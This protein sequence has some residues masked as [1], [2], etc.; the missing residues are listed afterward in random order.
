MD[1]GNGGFYIISNFDTEFSGAATSIGNS[2]STEYDTDSN[3]VFIVDAANSGGKALSFS[4]VNAGATLHLQWKPVYL[5]FL[6]YIFTIISSWNR[7]L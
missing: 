6:H 1:D 2:L 3:T 5:K 7:W 4:N